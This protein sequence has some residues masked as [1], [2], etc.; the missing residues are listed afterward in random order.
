M[1]ILKIAKMGSDVLKR[2]SKAVVNPV[3]EGIVQLARDMKN[4]SEDIG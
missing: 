1:A 2:E 4:T 3:D